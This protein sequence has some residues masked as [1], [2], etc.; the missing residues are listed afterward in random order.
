MADIV[1]LFQ[2]QKSKNLV[3]DENQTGFLYPF[4]LHFLLWVLVLYFAMLIEENWK[5]IHLAT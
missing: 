3:F 4:H 5:Q 1:I 2:I